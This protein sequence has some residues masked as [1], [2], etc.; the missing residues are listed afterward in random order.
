MFCTNCG[1]QLA[2]GSTYCP[3]CGAALAPRPE[4][5]PEQKQN[6][7]RAFDPNAAIGQEADGHVNEEV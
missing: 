7:A 2:N 4:P 1:R 5:T 6:D 3:F